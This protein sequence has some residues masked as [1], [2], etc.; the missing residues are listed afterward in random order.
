[1]KILLVEDDTFLS[2]MYVTKFSRLGYDI[3]T[4]Y[5]GEEGLKK[6]KKQK[7]DIILLDIRLPIKNGFEVLKELKQDDATKKIPVLLLTNLGQKED[8][9]KG[10]KLGAR[11][12]MIKSQFTPQEVVEKVKNIIN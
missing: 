3:D 10:I 9:E 12:Y 2:D 4:A 5:D 7:P 1:M 6:I 8:I 11:D